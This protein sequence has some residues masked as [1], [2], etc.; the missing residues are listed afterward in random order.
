MTTT[1]NP[2]DEHDQMKMSQLAAASGLTVSTIKFYMSQG[3]LPRPRKAKPNVAYYDEAFLKR[4]LIVKKMRDE[5]LSVHSIKVI[6]DKYSFSKVTEWEAF[7]K[8]AKKKDTRDLDEEERLA[9]LSGEQRRTD[10]ILEAAFQ[11]FSV[12]GYHNATVDDIAQQAGVSKG[13]CYQYFAGKE[14]IFLATMDRTMDQLFAEAEATAAGMTNALA[15]MGMQGLTFVSRF[16]ELQFMFFGLYT[17]VLGGNERLRKKAGE[18]F[19]KVAAFIARDIDL[20]MEQKIFRK[21]D[22]MNVGY[23]MLGIAQ[24][25]GNLSLTNEDFDAVDF[26]VGLMDFMQHG[27]MADNRPKPAKKKK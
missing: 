20:G 23:A 12:R 22:P 14:E 9:T 16:K 4:L 26:F 6:L 7:K 19:D 15:R 8:Q 11:V 1:K 27:I 10:A 21:V 2:K 3:L 25:V 17:E 13:T 24:A 5:G 18:L